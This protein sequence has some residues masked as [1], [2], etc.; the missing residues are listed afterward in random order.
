MIVLDIE[1]SGK[2]TIGYGVWQI[3]ALEYEN[4]KNT[5]LEEARID[6]EDNVTE[7]ALKITG[8]TEGEL[9]DKN[10]QSQ[11]ELIKNFLIWAGKCRERIIAGHNVWW[12]LIFLQN[13]CLKYGLIKD[14][15]D[16]LGH[17]VLDLSTLAQIRYKE[18]H[19]KF[20]IEK[21]KNAMNLPAVM[22]FCGMKDNR[23]KIIDGKITSGEPHNALE[24]VKLA[25]KC[26]RR[27]LK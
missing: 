3:G 25:E 18:K 6:D 13:R 15:E 2:Y 16:I 14:F 27:L 23:R 20:K 21:E 5:F 10:K 26:F 17:R 12:D 24:D 7:E 22:E 11:K 8:K 9:R 4:P 1:A 19:G